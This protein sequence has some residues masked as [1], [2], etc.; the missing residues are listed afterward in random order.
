MASA[1]SQGAQRGLTLDVVQA[2]V[3]EFGFIL[4]LIFGGCCSNAWA[5]ELTTKQLPASGTLLTLVQFIATAFV[6]L[7]GQLEWRRV[8]GM[9]MLVIKKP[10]VPLRRWL[11]QVLLYFTT[12][13]LNNT[14]FAYS[15]PMSVHI[16]FR[17][18]GMVVNMLL[19]YLIDKKR[20]APLQVLSV[21]LVTAGV[22]VATLSASHPSHASHASAEDYGFGVL[23]LSLALLSSGIMG[24]FQERTYA[25]YGREHWH[26]ALL[27]S[28]LFSLPLFLLHTRS[29]SEQVRAANATRPQWIGLQAW[30]MHIPSYYVVLALNVLTQLLCV[31][32]VN[33]LT[34]RVTSL[35]V[36]LVL[37]VRK[38]ASLVVSVV[39]LNGHTGNVALWGGAAAVMIGTVGYT[40]GGLQRPPKI[41]AKAQ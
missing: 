21:A 28:H 2:V 8:Y 37:V 12:S 25:I 34:S 30:G 39:L 11:V 4:A 13:L 6:A 7:L 5:L 36:S 41:R 24:I 18:G 16:V 22:V 33:R 3:G 23:L 20:Y 35:S 19:G 26:E 40:Y 1:R 31:N 32:G 14:A 15:I 10:G 29:L 27:Y 38:A 9:E 17:S